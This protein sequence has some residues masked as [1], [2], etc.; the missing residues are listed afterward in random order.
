MLL[1]DVVSSVLTCCVVGL[2]GV[3][4]RAMFRQWTAMCVTSGST[5]GRKCSYAVEYEL[6]YVELCSFKLVPGLSTHQGVDAKHAAKEPK[7]G[8]SFTQPSHLPCRKYTHTYPRTAPPQPPAETRAY[9]STPPPARP[10]QH[11]MNF[12]SLDILDGCKEVTK[13]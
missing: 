3:G 6:R 12:S 8:H 2:L 4:S 7:A 9:T 13:T 11:H 5:V 10:T 1:V